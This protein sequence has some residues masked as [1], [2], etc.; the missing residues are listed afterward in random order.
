MMYSSSIMRPNCFIF[1]ALKCVSSV[2]YIVK[3]FELNRVDD[4]DARFKSILN[5]SS[6]KIAG[7]NVKVT[8]TSVNVAV[9]VSVY[10][11]LI[12]TTLFL[13]QYFMTSII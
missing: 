4:D 2:H 6:V 11:Y 9:E 7:T 5:I 13:N 8:E 12:L 3:I 1:E 10:Q